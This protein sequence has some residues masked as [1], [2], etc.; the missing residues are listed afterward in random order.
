MPAGFEVVVDNT[1][2][3]GDVEV[4]I[5]TPLSEDSTI[6]TPCSE[7]LVLKSASSRRDALFRT[8]IPSVL[9]QLPLGWQSC[10]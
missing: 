8:N 10:R 5:V 1:V 2:V 7:K 9:V 6:G 4:S 3:S